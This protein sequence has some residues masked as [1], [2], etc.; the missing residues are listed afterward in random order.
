VTAVVAD[1]HTRR[2]AAEPIA[3]P[4]GPR[5]W[6]VF[7]ASVGSKFFD[8]LEI[9]GPNEHF[10]PKPRSGKESNT[11]LGVPFQPADQRYRYLGSSLSE[12]T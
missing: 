5:S 12:R 10:H 4:R 3:R 6:S 11:R 8:E 2:Q 9:G 7:T 1:L